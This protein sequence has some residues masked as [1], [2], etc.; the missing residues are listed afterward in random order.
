MNA[1]PSDPRSDRDLLETLSELRWNRFHTV[2]VLLFG[3]GWALDAFEVTLIGNVLGALRQHFGLGA[4]AMS[5]ILAAWFAGLMLGASGFGLLSDRFGRRRVFLASLVLYGVATLATAF[6]PD[7]ASLIALR[8]IAGIG[9][10]AEYSAINAAIA[11]LMPRKSRG[12]ASALVLN[13]WPVGSFVAAVLA[14]LVLSALPPDIGW[15]V[16]FGLG[17]MI[18]LSAAWFRRYLPESP[19]WLIAAGRG[20]EARAVIAGIEAGLTD[21][22]P[23]M[24]APLHHRVRREAGQFVTLVRDYPGRLALG[25]LL[26]FAEA[27]G[28]YGLFAFLPIVVLPALDLPADRLPVFYLVGSVGALIGGFAAAFLLDRLG[29][30]V[31]VAGFYLATAAGLVGF[32]AITGMGAGAIMVG[33]ALVNL[34]ATGS[35]IA[36]YPT[37]SELF[38]T[39]LRST[40]IGAS[41]AIGRIGAAMS[42]FLVG[43]VGARSMQAALIMLAGFWTLGAIAILIWRWGGGVEARGLGLELIDGVVQNG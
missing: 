38:P 12:R 9:V 29:R 18:A 21:I 19:R 15:R 27:S 8:L 41:V 1:A 31:T 14:W 2:V 10:G 37:F 39:P 22:R 40:G 16:V 23:A 34:L 17:G 32:A 25:A 6:A 11:E 5:F 13:F 20:D 36:A 28:Y 24:V 35:W 3:L 42:P 7:F 43:Y 4:Y 33:F 30:S 26:D